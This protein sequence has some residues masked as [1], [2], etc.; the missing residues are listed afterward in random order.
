M[1][2][3]AVVTG[4]SRGIGF[5]IARGLGREGREV[6]LVARDPGRLSAAVG[7][8]RAE[9]IVASFEAANLA[10]PEETNRL[11]E[12]LLARWPTIQ[13]L[14]NNAGVSGYRRVV[15]LEDS[16]WNELLETNL[17]TIFR[18]TRALAPSLCSS[19]AGAI[20]NVGSVAGLR[21]IEGL[22]AYC[23]A[24]A[25][26]H[27]LTQALA[28]EL[29]PCGVRVNAVAPGFIRTDLFEHVNPPAL[30]RE[31]GEAHPIG[32][33][34]T[35]AEVAAVVTFLCSASAS[36]VTG[37]VIPVDGGLTAKLAVPPLL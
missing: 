37:A 8:L 30:Q 11:A 17:S 32:R 13:V 7:D 21:A 18:L 9:G 33:V 19:G 14:V 22:A 20:V 4:A 23:T 1:P 6:V 34:G 25:G 2:P 5:D 24:K 27:T 16:A 12:R 28:L 36:F 10:V 35:G 26:V 31:L 29:A 3:V 15:E